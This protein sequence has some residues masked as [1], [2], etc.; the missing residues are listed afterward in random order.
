MNF[1]I[2]EVLADMVSAIKGELNEAWGDA[3]TYGSEILNRRKERME[4]LAQ[5]MLNSEI[6]K[7]KF[8]SRLEDEKIIIEAEFHAIAVVTKAM[9]ER[10]ANAAIDVLKKAVGKAI[11]A[12]L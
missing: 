4:L 2:N 8:L 10:A 12:A 5:L 9:A 3:K 7:E 6:S 11:D 1:D